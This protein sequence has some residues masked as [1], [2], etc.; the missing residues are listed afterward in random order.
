MIDAIQSRLHT[1]LPPEAGL[2]S[3][4]AARSAV[5]AATNPQMPFADTNDP[6]VHTSTKEEA[7]AIE[8]FLAEAD[9]QS[10]PVD[11]DIAHLAEQRAMHSLLRYQTQAVKHSTHTSTESVD[12]DRFTSF[13]RSQVRATYSAI[14]SQPARG[15][16]FALYKYTIR[17]ILREK[18][19]KYNT[20]AIYTFGIFRG[21][22][23]GTCLFPDLEAT[24]ATLA[25]AVGP[26]RLRA[27][28]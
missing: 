25:G 22:H 7:P 4:A 3:I 16:F 10:G 6:E 2:L 18:M 27:Q 12:A 20:G 13:W 28:A 17:L 14:L 23:C 21:A 26:T 5:T 15:S 9:D 8:I 1:P 19:R 11:A 24:L